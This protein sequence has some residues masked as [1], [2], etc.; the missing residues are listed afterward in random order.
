MVICLKRGANCL[1]MVQLMPLHPKKQSSLASFKSRLVLPFWYWL[2][3]AVLEQRPLNGRSVFCIPIQRLLR[4][5]GSAAD[6]SSV[7]QFLVSCLKCTWRC[8]VRAVAAAA[9][10]VSEFLL[11]RA[12]SS[13][14]SPGVKVGRH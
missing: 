14:Y 13:R 11:H 10:V 2:T 8:T 3:Q 7:A 1:H 6:V 4:W 12:A 9:A 5:C